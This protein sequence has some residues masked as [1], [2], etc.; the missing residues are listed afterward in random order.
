MMVEP[1]VTAVVVLGSDS[2]AMKS[3]EMLECFL[4]AAALDQ[5]IL[6]YAFMS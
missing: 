2:A 6:G 3:D 4:D 5:F 1:A